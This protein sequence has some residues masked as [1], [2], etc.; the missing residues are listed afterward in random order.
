[1]ALPGASLIVFAVLMAGGVILAELRRVRTTN[2]N[3]IYRAVIDALPEPMNAKDPEGRFVAANPATAE[4][5]RAGSAAALIG[6]TDFDFYPPDIAATFREDEA[7]AMESGRAEI[8]EQRVER[9][10]GSSAWLSTLKVPLIDPSGAIIGL[11]THN[12]DITALKKLRA[13]HEAAQRLLAD[14][15]A[16]MADGLAVYDRDNRLVMCNDQY[17]LM[18][19]K[20]AHLRVPGAGFAEILRAL[21]VTGEQAGVPLD[22]IE[23]WIE[24][25]SK[26]L[27]TGGDVPIQLGDGRW[28]RARIWPGKD[29]G[30][31][32]VISDVTAQREAER[33]LAELNRGL[34]ALARIDSLTGLGNRRTFEEALDGEFK[35]SARSGAPL[36]LL[37]LD[38]DNFKALNDTYGHQAGDACLRAIAGAVGVAMR[39]PGD[40]AAR[41][42]GEELVAI[43]PET[44]AEGAQSRA[45]AVL[46]AVRDLAIPHA[47][48][49]SGVVTVSIGVA[50][51]AGRGGDRAED[52]VHR[53]DDALYA[54]KAA[55][56]DRVEA[57]RPHLVQAR[58]G[59]GAPPVRFRARG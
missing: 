57:S 30:S 26:A 16:N 13:D 33:K 37:L 14:A 59:A 41:Y 31:L 5:M 51:R 47:G 21:A 54:A 29:G 25:T 3:R 56:R 1:V 52:L 50:T 53:A 20:T 58:R 27:Q 7:A 6:K 40:L 43:L 4:L 8:I 10:D 19:P 35:R 23:G 2:E 9:L 55:G 45:E 18:F 15:L 32:V 17:R 11:L 36:S 42:G 46:G 28:L 39:R 22:D 44:D 34:E 48:N 49:R 12:R 38:V 24:R